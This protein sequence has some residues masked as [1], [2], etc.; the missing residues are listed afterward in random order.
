M[1]IENDIAAD[2]IWD[3]AKP[4]D[5]VTE[6]PGGILGKDEFLKLLVTQLSY[7]DPLDPMDNR[8]SIAQLAQFSALEQ[9]QN[10]ATQVEG[11]RQA[12]GLTDGL[13]LQ[14]KD[15][16]AVDVNG[17]LYAGIIEGVSW[18]KEGTMLTIGEK[19]V[20]LAKIAE[21]RF[22][23]EHLDAVA[24]DETPPEAGEFH[25][26]VNEDAGLWEPMSY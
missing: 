23:G 8:E 9:M 14:G 18:G 26:E 21:L 24:G 13:L 12:Q 17:T 15:V 22:A 5:P 25:E 20:P 1:E 10:V 11:L 6:P 3:T 2:L 16:E 7:Q 19:I 4:P